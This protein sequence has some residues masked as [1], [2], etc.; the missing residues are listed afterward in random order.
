MQGRKI[1]FPGNEGTSRGKNEANEQS[2]HPTGRTD[3]DIS[4]VKE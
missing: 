3:D 1:V 4:K 2:G